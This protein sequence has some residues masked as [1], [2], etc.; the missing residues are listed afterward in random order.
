[1]TLLDKNHTNVAAPLRG[2]CGTICTEAHVKLAM[3][4]TPNGIYANPFN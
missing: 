4:L 2:P 3:S 1:M